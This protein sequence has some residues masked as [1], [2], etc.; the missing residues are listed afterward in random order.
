MSVDVPF[1]TKNRALHKPQN[2]SEMY[3]KSNANAFRIHVLRALWKVFPK[4][5]TLDCWAA[6]ARSKWGSGN[7]EQPKKS[8]GAG[9]SIEY[10]K[11]THTHE[12]IAIII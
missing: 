9:H 6:Q 8:K 3:P 7:L 5:E 1:S 2:T 11:M 4:L 12:I 10:C